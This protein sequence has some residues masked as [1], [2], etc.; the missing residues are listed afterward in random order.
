VTSPE[1]REFEQVTSDLADLHREEVIAY[2]AYR[3]TYLR[4]YTSFIG[5]GKSATEAR[6]WAEASAIVTQ[7][8]HLRLKA[9]IVAL[10]ER[11]QFLSVILGR[12]P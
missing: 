11:K 12:L 6:V 1:V 2:L 7:E 5:A 4:D 9:E 10:S 3:K 8:H